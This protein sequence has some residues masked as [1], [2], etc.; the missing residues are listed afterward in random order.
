MQHR[1]GQLPLIAT[2]PEAPTSLAVTAMSER[3]I[4]ICGGLMPRTVPGDEGIQARFRQ[5]RLFM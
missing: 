1:L 2:E 5:H 3:L 4:Q